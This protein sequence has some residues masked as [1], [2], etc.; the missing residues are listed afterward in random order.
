MLIVPGGCLTHFVI[1]LAIIIPR[2]LRDLPPQAYLINARAAVD[3]GDHRGALQPCRQALELLA[4]KIWRWLGQCDL[5]VISVQLAGAGD[6]PSLRNLC[7]G[8]RARLKGARTFVHGDKERL[9]DALNQ[10]LGIPEQTLLWQYLNKGTHEEQDRED[11][12]EGVV[13]QLVALMEQMNSLAL[14]KS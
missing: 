13:E 9:L 6:Q 14:R 4:N 1:T 7:D 8:L 12:D 10:I 5:G 3:R 2:I 11:F